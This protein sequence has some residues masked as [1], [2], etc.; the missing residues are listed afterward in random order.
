[1]DP[2]KI[3]LAASIL[4]GLSGLFALGAVTDVV[5]GA[6]HKWV[7]LAVAV[8]A[9][10][11]Q[12]LESRIPARSSA[13]PPAAALALVFL[14]GASACGPTTWQEGVVRT[15]DSMREATSK[16]IPGLMKLEGDKQFAKCKAMQ[17]EPRKECLGKLAAWLKAWH[18][19]RAALQTTI[20]AL[21]NLYQ[22]FKDPQ[23]AAPLPAPVVPARPPRSTPALPAMAPAPR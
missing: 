20:Q 21:D 6:Y 14:L 8:T 23:K 17:G 19:A 12:W 1:M 22:N 10:V 3:K 16:T 9:Y 13:T 18:V 5:P 15:A 2:K 11:A 4:A 7:A